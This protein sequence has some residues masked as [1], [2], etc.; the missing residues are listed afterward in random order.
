MLEIIEK[1]KRLKSTKKEKNTWILELPLEVCNKEGFARG[2]M[3]S[4]TIKNGGIQ[5]L[6][7]H[8]SPEI[9]N[10]VSRVI[11]EEKEFFEEMKRIG[12]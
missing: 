2:T 8:P 5:S 3:I 4:L 7:I 10:F 12:D 6:L 1:I 11:E 9:D